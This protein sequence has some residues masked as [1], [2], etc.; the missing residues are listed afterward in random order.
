MVVGADGFGFVNGEQGHVI[1][2]MGG[3]RLEEQVELGANACVDRGSLLDTV[4]G[5]GSKTD[6]FVQIGHGVEIGERALMV[7]YSGVAGSTTI[8]DAAR[9]GACIL[10]MTL[11]NDI[12][13]AAGSMVHRHL[14][15]TKSQPFAVKL[16]E[17]GCIQTSA[18]S[19]PAASSI[20]G[21]V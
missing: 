3:V 20:A 17:V 7:A 18:P 9:I 21:W 8:G 10:G 14:N 6:N 16:A 12:A 13:V 4:V 2:A 11:G 1:T 19:S 5:R 15:M